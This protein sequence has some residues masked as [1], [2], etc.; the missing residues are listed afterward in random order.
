MNN[1]PALLVALPNL[2]HHPTPATWAVLLGVNT[3]PVVVVSGSLASLL[4]LATLHRLG[5]K[6]GAADFA[7]F[8]ARVGLPAATCALG[9]AVALRLAGLN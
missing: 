8:G 2:G 9:A 7:R 5:V 3:G 6:A 4:W 1:L